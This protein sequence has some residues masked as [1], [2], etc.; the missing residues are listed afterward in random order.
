MSLLQRCLYYRG[1]FWHKICGK[2]D[3]PRRQAG[4]VRIFFCPRLRM[5][6]CACAIRECALACAF[7]HAR[8]R[9]HARKLVC[10]RNMQECAGVAATACLRGASGSSTFVSVI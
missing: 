9:V 1:V 7:E 2:E 3:L 10:A 4:P 5:R 6:A 8:M